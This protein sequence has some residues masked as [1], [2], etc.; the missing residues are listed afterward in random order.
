MGYDMLSFC[1]CENR[2]YMDEN[3]VFLCESSKK[4][5]KKSKYL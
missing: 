1:D 4:I 2:K 3:G 5:K